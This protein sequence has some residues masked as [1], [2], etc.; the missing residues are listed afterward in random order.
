MSKKKTVQLSITSTGFPLLQKPGDMCP[1]GVSG[2]FWNFT[3][4][5][6]HNEEANTLFKCTVFGFHVLHKWTGGSVPS[7]AMELQEMMWQL[8]ILFPLHFVVFEQ[9]ECHMT[10]E[11]NVE[12]VFSRM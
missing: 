8:R 12:Q 5:R 7:Q 3:R 2:K 1:L 10:D 11:A 9:T 6:M 4:D